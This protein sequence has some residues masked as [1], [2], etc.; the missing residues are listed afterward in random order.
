M[1]FHRPQLN[2]HTGLIV[3]Q[4]IVRCVICHRGTYSPARDSTPPSRRFVLGRPAAVDVPSKSPRRLVQIPRGRCFHHKH[5]SIHAHIPLAST[6]A[7]PLVQPPS[8][9]LQQSAFLSAVAVMQKQRQ[10]ALN[11][12]CADRARCVHSTRWMGGID[13]AIFRRHFHLSTRPTGNGNHCC[14]RLGGAVFI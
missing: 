8:S 7:C 3:L 9:L 5:C 14:W 10:S 1:V 13:W 2:P 4:S 12:N 6:T 11:S